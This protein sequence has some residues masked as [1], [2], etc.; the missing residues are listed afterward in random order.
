M[1]KI[2][3][4]ALET[5]LFGEDFGKRIKTG[6]VVT[7][8]GSLGSGKT[9]FVKGL[10]RGLGLRRKIKSP[11]FVIFYAYHIPKSRRY[12]YHFD[13]YRLSSLL[14]LDDLGFT[15][16]VKNKNN[17]IVV[18]WPEKCKKYLPAN[19]RRINF[20]HVKRTPGKRLIRI[21]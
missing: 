17:V 19:T 10:A 7:L 20:T 2:S 11:T 9:T 4:S 6:K 8:S 16:I 13:L 14:E 18:E 15:E 12:F 21:F 3:G 5:R 1:N